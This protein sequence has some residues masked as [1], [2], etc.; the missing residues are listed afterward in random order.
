MQA[1]VLLLLAFFAAAAFAVAV[2]NA[3]Y[4]F[5]AWNVVRNTIPALR[6]NVFGPN[7]NSTLQALAYV[8]VIFAIIAGLVF[9]GLVIA[10]IMS[11][12]RDNNNNEDAVVALP[13]A[14]RATPAVAT[15]TT[16]TAP[17]QVVTLGN[18]AASQAVALGN[19]TANRAA[20][21]PVADTA[22]PLQQGVSTAFRQ[23]PSVSQG[24]SA[25]AIAT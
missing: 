14:V 3:V 17:S 1:T 19:V 4:Y 21:T 12:L 16:T 13:T 7:S 15:T 2:T 9:C 24:S 25:S 23:V 20:T 8:N 10:G 5:R 22:S 18:T 11:L 6:S